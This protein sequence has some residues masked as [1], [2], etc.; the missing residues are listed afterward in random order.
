MQ[1]Q[2]AEA[3]HHDQCTGLC[4]KHAAGRTQAHTAHA[5]LVHTQLSFFLNYILRQT[6]DIYFS[7]EAISASRG[8]N[9]SCA[10]GLASCSAAACLAAA[11]AT[12]ALLAVALL[13]ALLPG[14]V[15]AA[16][17]MCGPHALRSGASSAV[18]CCALAAAQLQLAAAPAP[19]CRSC[20][21]TLHSSP[22][23]VSIA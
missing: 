22:S 19:G 14:A 11:T 17:A 12:A 2:K 20:S 8:P 7:G 9:T 4:T 15:A 21:T 5:W 10:A 6:R 3:T 16:A 13:G 18:Q 1:P 23:D